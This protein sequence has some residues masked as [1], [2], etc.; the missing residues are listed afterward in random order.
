[1]GTSSA[2]LTSE[3]QAERTRLA[4]LLGDLP[5]DQWDVPSL[6]AGWRVREVAAHITMP[7]RVKP[8]VVLAGII[9]AGF[10]FNRYADRDARSAARQRTPAELVDLLRRNIANP[11]SPPGGG[12]VGALSH[13]VIHGL[14][15]TEPLGLPGP[16]AER[17]ALVLAAAGPQQLR[18]FGVDLGGKRL[19]ATDAQVSVGSGPG[20]VSLTARE[21]LLVITGRRPLG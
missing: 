19:A 9:G 1:M 8:P 4:D 13:D 2:E 14:D 3:I 21:I 18:Y 20:V 15:V 7:F 10:S 6:C 12:S 5:P 17:I 11:W 16:P